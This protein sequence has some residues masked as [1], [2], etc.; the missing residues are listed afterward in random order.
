MDAKIS[1]DHILNPTYKL[2]LGENSR[3]PIIESSNVME[4]YKRGTGIS[5][6]LS[7]TF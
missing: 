5:L 7:Y 3:V 4:D 6:N 1:V 2:E